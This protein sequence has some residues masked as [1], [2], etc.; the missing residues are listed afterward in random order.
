MKAVKDKNGCNNIWFV[1]EYKN[2]SNV[3]R[4]GR[5][6][7]IPNGLDGKNYKWFEYNEYMSRDRKLCKDTFIKPIHWLYELSGNETFKRDK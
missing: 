3:V 6:H 4:V 5:K 1:G 2:L 7:Y